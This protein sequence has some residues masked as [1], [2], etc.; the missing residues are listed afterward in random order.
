MNQWLASLYK[1]TVTKADIKN[2][3]TFH[4]FDVT[5]ADIKGDERDDEAAAVN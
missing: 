1:V 4:V 2:I 5:K 3:I